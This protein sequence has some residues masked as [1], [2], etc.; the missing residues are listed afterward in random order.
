DRPAQ[1][2]RTL[3]F[4]VHPLHNPRRLFQVYQPLVERINS[5]LDST[6]IRLEASR[7]YAEFEKKLTDRYFHFAL[8]NP[9]Q[10]MLGESSGYRVFGKMGDDEQFRGIIIVRKDGGIVVPEDLRGKAVSY[11]APTALAATMLPQRFLHSHGLDVRKDIE[12]RYVGSQES[13]IMNVYLGL[14]AAGA[15]W[16]PP[17]LAFVKERPEIAQHL[18]VKW[19]TASLVNNSLMARDDVPSELVDRVGQ[20][21]FALHETTEGRG[22]L[23]AM[24]LSRFEPAT[25]QAYQPVRDFLTRFERDIRPVKG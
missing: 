6:R 11:P 7:N 3:V 1:Q 16:P 15:T 24:E 9:Y 8:P 12:N 18:E 13:S 2:G 19:R 5:H 25:Q 21:I 23:A 4:G 14:T 22:I 17:W 20:V 10:T